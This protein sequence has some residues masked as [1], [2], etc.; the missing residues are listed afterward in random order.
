LTRRVSQ[1]N[2]LASQRSK[3]MASKRQLR[4]CLLHVLAARFVLQSDT[5]EY[6]EAKLANDR[7]RYEAYGYMLGVITEAS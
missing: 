7:D 5:N 3:Q 2:A 6:E 4:K 1:K